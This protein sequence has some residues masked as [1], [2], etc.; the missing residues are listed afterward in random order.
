[1]SWGTGLL[2]RD[3][4]LCSRPRDHWQKSAPCDE[5]RAERVEGRALS[6]SH[7]R[8]GKERLV[9]VEGRSEPCR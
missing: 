8:G 7:P 9:K 4:A 2:S 1:M 6:K 3:W 5:N